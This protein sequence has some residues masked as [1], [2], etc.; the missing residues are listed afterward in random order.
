M[1]E[2]II[3]PVNIGSQAEAM[4]GAQAITFTATDRK[5]IADRSGGEINKLKSFKEIFADKPL[6]PK[7]E[8]E[9]TSV[10]P[11]M[12]VTEIEGKLK[13][14]QKM[15]KSSPI[16][17]HR[18]KVIIANISPDQAELQGEAAK[19]APYTPPSATPAPADRKLQQET[20][21]IAREL[22]LDP[23]QLFDKFELEQKELYSLVLKIRDLHLKRLLCA[24]RQ[25]FEVLSAE[26]EK[27]TLASARPEA[28]SWFQEQLKGLKKSAAKY[29]L[30]LVRSLHSMHIDDKT[31]ESELKWL[32]QVI[33]E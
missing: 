1:A 17:S 20:L 9:L 2:P 12:D 32:K 18:D 7:V 28:R 23:A 19:S 8:N 21:A 3:S 29:K 27:E 15:L 26:I 31:M 10:E 24:G 6:S 13:E 11:Q 30:N 4:A 16:V 5:V 33:E 14:H 25:D 22:N